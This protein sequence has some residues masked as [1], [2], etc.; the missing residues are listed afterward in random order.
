MYSMKCWIYG[1]MFCTII[2]PVNK[3]SQGIYYFWGG[4]G[5]VLVSGDCLEQ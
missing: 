2:L 4:G 1:H 3:D 5:G